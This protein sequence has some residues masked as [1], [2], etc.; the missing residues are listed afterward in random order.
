MKR[1]IIYASG[2]FQDSRN[3]KNDVQEQFSELN[4]FCTQ[5]GIEVEAVFLDSNDERLAD[6][7]D[8]KHL[9]SYANEM[10]QHIDLCVFT[11]WDRFST[12]QR[13]LQILE[14]QFQKLDIKLV[15]IEDCT[16]KKLMNIPKR[17]RERIARL[18]ALIIND[19]EWLCK[20]E[21]TF[22]RAKQSMIDKTQQRLERNEQRLLKITDLYTP[23]ELIEQIENEDFQALNTGGDY[24]NNELSR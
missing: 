4:C 18:S 21:R 16:P 19:H 1:A 8:L 12:N 14:L 23:N 6:R 3:L 9:L 17:T 10:K 7:T 2:E 20:Q 13:E 22:S 5:H 15:A 11:S 24:G